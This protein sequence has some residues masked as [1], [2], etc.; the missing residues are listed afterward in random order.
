MFYRISIAWTTEKYQETR[1]KEQRE[2][3]NIW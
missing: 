1:E 2:N 3:I